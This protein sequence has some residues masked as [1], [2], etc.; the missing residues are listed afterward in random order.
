MYDVTANNHIQDQPKW[1]DKISIYNHLR[2]ASLAFQPQKKKK[3][4]IAISDPSAPTQPIQ[5][6]KL[7]QIQETGERVPTSYRRR[8]TC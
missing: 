3:I 7:Q 4:D 8:S 6:I 2:M 1:T 5:D